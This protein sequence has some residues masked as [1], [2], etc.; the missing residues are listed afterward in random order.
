MIE[1]TL[2][3]LRSA[4]WEEGGDYLIGFSYHVI[5]TMPDTDGQFAR[6]IPIALSCFS[7]KDIL[8]FCRRRFDLLAI[9][10]TVI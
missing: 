6:Q 9:E 3:P 10:R 4:A 8:G 2:C 1:L 7:H 5:T